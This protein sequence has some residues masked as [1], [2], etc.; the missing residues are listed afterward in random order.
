MNTRQYS[1]RKAS[2]RMTRSPIYQAIRER[3]L[4]AEQ[5]LADLRVETAA[6]RKERMG[7]R[8]RI[9]GLTRERDAM[10]RER[11]AMAKVIDVQEQ[12]LRS[13]ETTSEQTAA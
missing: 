7:Q 11:D 1:D 3:A 10:A 12:E 8:Q 4:V 9:D 6:L 2:K 13:H 5:A